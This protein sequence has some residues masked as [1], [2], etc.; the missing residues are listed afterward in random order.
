MGWTQKANSGGGNFE[1][2]PA[3]THPAVLVGII[4]LGTQDEN[5]NGVAKKAHKAFL[6]WEIPGEKDA[7][8]QSHIIG[9]EY[10]V[11]FHE[12]AGLRQMV[13]AWRGK[14]FTEGEEFDLSKLMGQACLLTVITEEKNGKTFSKLK[15]VG[16]LIKGMAKPVATIAPISFNLEENHPSAFPTFEWL[17]WSYGSKLIDI[18]ANS[19]EWKEKANG[20]QTAKPAAGAATAPATSPAAKEAPTFEEVGF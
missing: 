2:C 11:S 16:G 3:G 19:P 9:R 18:A 8:G 6:M 5:F 12:K 7:S 14:P 4:D 15:G 1:A 20:Q 13:E 17:P 10:T